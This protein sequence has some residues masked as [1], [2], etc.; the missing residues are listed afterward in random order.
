M[1]LDGGLAPVKQ[2]SGAIRNTHP[3]YSASNQNVSTDE[4]VPVALGAQLPS[5]QQSP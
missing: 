3:C 5:G 2:G 4:N 1:A